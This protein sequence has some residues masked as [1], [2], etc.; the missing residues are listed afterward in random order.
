MFRARLDI[1]SLVPATME[2]EIAFVYE[3][4]QAPEKENRLIKILSATPR[5]CCQFSVASLEKSPVFSALSYMWGNANV[6][7][8]VIVDGGKLT[9][10]EKRVHVLG[11]GHR[12]CPGERQITILLQA[13]NNGSGQTM[14]TSITKIS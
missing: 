5:I 14:F 12:Q 3:P 2:S 6:T 1:N 4:L 7:Q 13:T 9:V 8:L 11:D 10:T